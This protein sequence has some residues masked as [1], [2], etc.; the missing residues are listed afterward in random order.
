MNMYNET[1]EY[2]SK[3]DYEK[4]VEENKRL[5]NILENIKQYILSK[6]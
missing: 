1:E 5:I 4:V 3:K 2:V 6:S